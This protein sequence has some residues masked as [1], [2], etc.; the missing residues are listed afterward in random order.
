VKGG[1][2][3]AEPKRKQQAPNCQSLPRAKRL[4]LFFLGV[5]IP[6]IFSVLSVALH[7]NQGIDRLGVGV[8]LLSLPL[9]YLVGITQIVPGLSASAILLSIGWFGFLVDSVSFSFWK[10]TPEIFLTYGMLGVGFLLGLLTFSKLLSAIFAKARQT[11]Y[12]MI[13]GLSL[14]SILSMFY[15]PDVFSVYAL[16]A[17]SGVRWLDLLLGIGLFVVGGIASYLLVRYERK[18]AKSE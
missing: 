15:N 8:I 16:W 11:S 4:A 5:L 9:G 6:L 18:K 2:G 14:G 12:F 1:C 3:N 10:E 17:N 7:K 13:V